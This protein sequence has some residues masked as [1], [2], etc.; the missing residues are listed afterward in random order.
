MRNKMF[1]ITEEQYDWLE[2]EANASKL[3]R[4]LLEGHIR[5]SKPTTIEEKLKRIAQLEAKLEY[6]KKL[7]AIDANPPRAD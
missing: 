1:C 4:D 7:E 2:N 5:L 6:E 3:I